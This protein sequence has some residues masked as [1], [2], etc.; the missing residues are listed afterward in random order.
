MSFTSYY[1]YV[2]SFL[3]GLAGA[4]FDNFLQHLL[5]PGDKT[6]GFPTEISLFNGCLPSV[7]T[8]Y[9]GYHR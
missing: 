2:G 9:Q 5:L 4:D 1:F 6:S 8:K 7:I 3:K